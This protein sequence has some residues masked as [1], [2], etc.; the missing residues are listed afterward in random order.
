MIGGAS[1]AAGTFTTLSAASLDATCATKTA[2][3]T[4][5]ATADFFVGVNTSSG[6]LTMTLPAAGTAGSG[7][8][9]VI[10]DVGGVAGTD[11]KNITITPNGS[12]KI[13]GQT[14]SR[15]LNTNHAAVNLMS[16]G[17]NWFLW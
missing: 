11:G 3:Y 13:D 16:D 9:Y 7:K 2:N 8:M 10:K 6:G 5:S 4:V 17:S 12:E 14:G 1:A 15:T